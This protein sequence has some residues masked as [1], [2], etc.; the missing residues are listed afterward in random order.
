MKD[1]NKEVKWFL[2]VVA[3]LL[4]AA[5]IGSIYISRTGDAAAKNEAIESAFEEAKE[6]MAAEYDADLVELIEIQELIEV[7]SGR[8]EISYEVILSWPRLSDI[9]DHLYEEVIWQEVWEENSI[10]RAVNRIYK[11]ALESAE[12]ESMVLPEEIRIVKQGRGTWQTQNPEAF[13]F[14]I[15]RNP[16]TYISE[17]LQR[18]TEYM[19][20]T[21]STDE[22]PEG[23]LAKEVVETL[24]ED[25]FFHDFDFN[26]HKSSDGYIYQLTMSFNGFYRDEEL[27]YLTVEKTYR[28]HR[29]EI[30]NREELM[31]VVLEEIEEKAKRNAAVHTV[32]FREYQ[33]PTDDHF[34]Y[35]LRYR[36]LNPEDLMLEFVDSEGVFRIDRLNF[37]SLKRYYLSTQIDHLLERAEPRWINEFNDKNP[38]SV[39]AHSDEIA[40]VFSENQEL[41]FQTYDF[42]TGTLKD[43]VILVD[44]YPVILFPEIEEYRDYQID[45]HGTYYVITDKSIEEKIWI[46]EKGTDGFILHPAITPEMEP[47][48]IN[49]TEDVVLYNEMVYTVK[50]H[51]D[52]EMYRNFAVKIENHSQNTPE[53]VI[54]FEENMSGGYFLSR[55]HGLMLVY[56]TMTMLEDGVTPESSLGIYNFQNEAMKDRD[57][58]PEALQ[59]VR[60][61]QVE[62]IDGDRLLIVTEEGN[63]WELDLEEGSF[64]MSG[65]T[66]ALDP[67]YEMHE[68]GGVY[69]ET[70]RFYPMK[71]GYYF[72]EILGLSDGSILRDKSMIV[73]DKEGILEPVLEVN[74]SIDQGRIALSYSKEND[75]FILA[76][77]LQEQDSR[78]KHLHLLDI[79][80]DALQEI[81]EL[82][83]VS[84]IE[85]L[86]S[87]GYAQEIEYYDETL[88]SEAGNYFS[89]S[90]DSLL[91]GSLIDAPG[92]MY[93][94]RKTRDLLIE[95]NFGGLSMNNFLRHFS[96]DSNESGTTPLWSYEDLYINHENEHIFY[97]D[98][99][100][101]MV[102]DLQDFIPALIRGRE[103]G[104]DGDS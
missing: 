71:Q 28:S 39:A 76:K 104:N 47:E 4:I 10:E 13:F 30:N 93:Y 12:R 59:G 65:L 74:H 48:F 26:Y 36:S 61:D 75:L 24:E 46:V 44:E 98:E 92:G 79:S 35:E 85:E 90:M 58:I 66:K 32:E 1:N 22:L 83:E 97:R 81:E 6:K 86:I 3:V 34:G 70:F 60:I 21:V 53:E 52:D 62:S 23:S 82:M 87:E 43:E 57:Q 94:S 63:L 89:V 78:Q 73:R 27:D 16:T 5:V 69:E 100:G 102:F 80:Y 95:N 31:N 67:T 101:M 18:M 45:N 37:E 8:D 51:E 7:N 38:L 42:E 88:E 56:P 19:G 72:L 2:G 41:I 96:D 103:D 68:Y 9:Y 15:P 49:Y 17:D 14:V 99:R 33:R 54:F 20:F 77:E 50:T 40:I 25:G 91:H 55:Q 64:Q 11:D 84:S 29:G